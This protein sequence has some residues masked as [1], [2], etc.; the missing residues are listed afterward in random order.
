MA[1]K[2]EPIRRT[3]V[4]RC[5][6]CGEDYSITYKRCPF[7]DE[8]PGRSPRAGTGSGG[9]R[10]SGGTNPLQVFILLLSLIPKT[11]YS[12]QVFA[13]TAKKISAVS[14][15]LTIPVRQSAVQQKK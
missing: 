10:V 3:D 13:H 8:R 12:T 5:E 11:S 14:T 1:T 2:Q 6:T 4:V 9:R 15:T 7:C